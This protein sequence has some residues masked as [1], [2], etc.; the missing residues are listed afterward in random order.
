MLRGPTR[1]CAIRTRFFGL[2][3]LEESDLERA[4]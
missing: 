1:D 3:R 2:L 4:M